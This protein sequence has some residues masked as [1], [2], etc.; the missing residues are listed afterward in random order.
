MNDET[1]FNV[2]D[3]SVVC[4]DKIWKLMSE[5]RDAS[6]DGIEITSNEAEFYLDDV[7]KVMKNSVKLLVSKYSNEGDPRTM[8][9]KL[10][11]YCIGVDETISSLSEFKEFTVTS[12]PVIDDMDG[13]L[14]KVSDIG[15]KFL[16]VQEQFVDEN[17]PTDVREQL[18]VK[19]DD[20]RASIRVEDSTTK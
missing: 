8:D 9:P 19:V 16:S 13:F 11:A 10:Y 2:Y 12:G 17:A 18:L 5:F 7:A 20:R 6:K 4:H 3:E 1:F 15:M 14:K